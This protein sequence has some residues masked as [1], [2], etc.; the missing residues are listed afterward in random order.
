M[1]NEAYTVRALTDSEIADNYRQRMKRD[2]PPNELKPLRMI[3]KSVER[4][5]YEC[6][7]MFA[8]DALLGYAFLLRSGRVLL[9]DY[10]AVDAQRRGTGIGSQFLGYLRENLQA[11]AVIIESE[12]PALSASDAERETRERR[13]RFYFRSGCVDSGLRAHVFGADYRVLQ[14]PINSE[15]DADTLK[16]EYLT[17]YRSML[18]ESLLR[19]NIRVEG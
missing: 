1:T 14:L 16:N 8:G 7:G 18:P 12:N 11:D 10:F 4:G 19:R 3:R 2:F 6:L 17:L 5:I 15:I 9:L 13:L